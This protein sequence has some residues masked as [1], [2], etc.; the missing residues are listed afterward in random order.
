MLS[1][2]IPIL[3]SRGANEGGDEQ[4]DRTA[5]GRKAHRSPPGPSPPPGR[6]NFGRPRGTGPRARCLR[7]EHPVA[8]KPGRNDSR[9]SSRARS[10]RPAHPN[11]PGRPR[12][13]GRLHRSRRAPPQRSGA[14]AE[15]RSPLFARASLRKWKG[16][17]AHQRAKPASARCAKRQLRPAAPGGRTK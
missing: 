15:P 2:R 16:K 7:V 5:P 17:S 6:G 11:A 9:G 12:T 1:T 8:R 14:R 4:N 13:G 3:A 10:S